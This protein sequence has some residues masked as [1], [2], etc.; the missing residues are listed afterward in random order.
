MHDIVNVLNITKGKFYVMCYL[1]TVFR[2]KKKERKINKENQ[3]FEC[4]DLRGKH[5]SDKGPFE[6]FPGGSVVNNPPCQCRRHKF[7]PWSGKIPRAME[8]ISPC[9]TTMELV[10]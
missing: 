10:L 9:T 1:T 4:E 5:K 6:G 2:K 7:N 8:Q 3:I